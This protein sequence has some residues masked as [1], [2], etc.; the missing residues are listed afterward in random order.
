MGQPSGA[1]CSQL[2]PGST[3]QPINW[4]LTITIFLIEWL[5]V[6]CGSLHHVMLH[7]Q[8]Q[9]QHS[10]YRYNTSP[11]PINTIP[12]CAY[13]FWGVRGTWCQS[14]LLFY[15]L[16]NQSFLLASNWFYEDRNLLYKTISRFITRGLDRIWWPLNG[17]W[18]E[19]YFR[20][21]QLFKLICQN[22]NKFY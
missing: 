8:N 4:C 16:F 14:A 3:N 1:N 15:W 5:S 7:Y 22:E 20:I 18:V 19:E 9:Y 21:N 10:H 13:W 6:G 11:T 2:K 17:L 12:T